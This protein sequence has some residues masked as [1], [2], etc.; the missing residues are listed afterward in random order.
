MAMGK[1]KTESQRKTELALKL[2]G[3]PSDTTKPISFRL[4]IDEA[5]ALAL[6]SVRRHLKPGQLVRSWVLERLDKERE[7]AVRGDS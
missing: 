4:P 7:S 3:L 2:A 5:E 1:K 6:L